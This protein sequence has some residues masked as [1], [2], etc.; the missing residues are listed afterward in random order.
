MKE[1]GEG[2]EIEMEGDRLGGIE[3]RG[4]EIKTEGRRDGKRE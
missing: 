2:N 3:I 1:R 4:K